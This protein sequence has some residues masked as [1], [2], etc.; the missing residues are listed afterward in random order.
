V[1]LDVESKA[2]PSNLE[3]ALKEIAGTI[4]VRIL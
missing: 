2:I 3:Q 1:V 4:S